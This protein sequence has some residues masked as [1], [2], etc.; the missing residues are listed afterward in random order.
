MKRSA[1]QSKH[2]QT[3]TCGNE[4]EQLCK[5]NSDKYSMSI[6]DG[7]KTIVCKLK[8]QSSRYTSVG[9]P[10]DSI[11]FGSM[12]SQDLPSD[13]EAMSNAIV[14]LKIGNLLDVLDW[15]LQSATNTA[16]TSLTTYSLNN[17]RI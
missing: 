2:A 16:N 10:I 11:T 13:D 9:Y 3:C 4:L 1:W 15:D 12:V 6:V 17:I 7:A 14:D 5:M 8:P